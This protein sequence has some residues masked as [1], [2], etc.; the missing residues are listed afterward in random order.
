MVCDHLVLFLCKRTFKKKKNL[1]EKASM[2]VTDGYLEKRNS[3]P[4]AEGMNICARCSTLIFQ[5]ALS[6]HSTELHHLSPRR[7]L[8]S[9]PPT[10]KVPLRTDGTADLLASGTGPDLPF[11]SLS[12]SR[13]FQQYRWV[14]CYRL[15]SA[16]CKIYLTTVFFF[17]S[18]Q[19][20]S[21]LI[22][23]AFRCCKKTNAPS[24]DPRGP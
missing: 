14:S 11:S 16:Y 20:V 18:S 13:R 4:F 9:T 5:F 8:A 21:A 24:M 22:S 10:G 23:S 17:L 6:F 3:K 19:L 2:T 7:P 12:S 15:L 1:S